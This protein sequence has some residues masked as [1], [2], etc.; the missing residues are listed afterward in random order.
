MNNPDPHSS[1]WRQ[2]TVALVIV[3]AGV[4]L[5]YKMTSGHDGPRPRSRPTALG[6]NIPV[7][8]TTNAQEVSTQSLETSET[9]TIETQR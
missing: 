5:G 4:V 3:L 9:N 6:H 7:I 8:Q 2:F 1:S